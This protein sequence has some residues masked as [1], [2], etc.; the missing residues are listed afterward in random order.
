MSG[1]PIL[2]HATASATFLEPL[3]FISNSSKYSGNG[4]VDK[5]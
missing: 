3:L 1:L 5:S 2:T 4:K